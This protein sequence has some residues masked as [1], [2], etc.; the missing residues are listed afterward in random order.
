MS[1]LLSSRQTHLSSIGDTLCEYV[2]AVTS[3]EGQEIDVMGWYKPSIM[4]TDRLV[5]EPRSV[6][7]M[8]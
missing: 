5:K 3:Q 4:D 6:H 2:D 1:C 7:I 8:D